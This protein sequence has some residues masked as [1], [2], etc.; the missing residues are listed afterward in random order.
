MHTIRMVEKTKIIPV[1]AGLVIC[2]SPAFEN[3][4]TGHH[5]YICLHVCVIVTLYLWLSKCFNSGFKLLLFH[6][7]YSILILIS[8]CWKKG[9]L[10]FSVLVY[11]FVLEIELWRVCLCVCRGVWCMGTVSNTACVIRSPQSFLLLHTDS[12]SLFLFLHLSFFLWHSCPALR[13]SS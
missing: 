12:L 2:T 4:S 7:K 1:N 5:T 11:L 13:V 9:D 3:Y 6:F 8:L 10:S